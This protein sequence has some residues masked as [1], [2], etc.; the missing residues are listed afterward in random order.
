MGVCCSKRNKILGDK[1]D[2]IKTSIE[3]EKDEIEL[4]L[5]KYKDQSKI[6]LID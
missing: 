1:I 6:R 5:D 4:L 2:E 3:K